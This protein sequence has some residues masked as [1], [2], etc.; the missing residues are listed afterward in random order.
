MNDLI[1]LAEENSGAG[2]IATTIVGIVVLVVAAV[3]V[4]FIVKKKRAKSQDLREKYYEVLVS[5]INDNKKTDYSINEIRNALSIDLSVSDSTIANLVIELN[6]SNRLYRQ[7]EYYNN[8]IHAVDSEL[9]DYSEKLILDNTGTKVFKMGIDKDKKK[10]VFVINN[11][12]REFDFKEILSYEV[13]QQDKQVLHSETKSKTKKSAGKAIVGNALFGTEGAIIGTALATS[14]TKENT[15]QT[16]QDFVD[17]Y[18]VY[19]K[20]SQFNNPVIT[21]PFIKK[22]TETKSK[23]YLRILEDSNKLTAVLDYILSINESNE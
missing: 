20:T 3:V 21:I 4:F 9:D 11:D 18:L 17:N 22:Q 13:Y 14:K 15:T 6:N 1:F 12:I 10:C 5:Y 8:N 23:K 2:N 16:T 7:F 19:I